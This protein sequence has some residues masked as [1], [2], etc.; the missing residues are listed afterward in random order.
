MNI[1]LTFSRI[2]PPFISLISITLLYTRTN[3]YHK[4]PVTRFNPIIFVV[5]PFSGGHF[6]NRNSVSP[7]S[8]VCEM[9]LPDIQ[10]SLDM[11]DDNKSWG[12]ASPPPQAH[13]SIVLYPTSDYGDQPLWV[14]NG[15]LTVST[16]TLDKL[17]HCRMIFIAIGRL[18]R[19]RLDYWTIISLL[20]LLHFLFF[21]LTFG[22]T[23]S[24]LTSLH[25]WLWEAPLSPFLWYPRLATN[26]VSAVVSCM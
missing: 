2:I 13:S 4:C 21:S 8:V 15:V 3:H 24:K 5:C 1:L 22:K 14:W 16:L 18:E 17:Y 11:Y 9:E 23:I 25:R 19:M 20:T 10:A 6:F 7:R 26:V 12:H